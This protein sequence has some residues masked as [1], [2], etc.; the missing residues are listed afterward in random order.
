MA[1]L[2]TVLRQSPLTPKQRA[3]LWDLYQNAPDQDALTTALGGVNIPKE[4][5]AKLWDLK[6]TAL[7]VPAASE[8]PAGA[9]ALRQ[10]EGISQAPW[11]AKGMIAGHGPSVLQALEALPAVGGAVGGILGGGAGIPSGPGAVATAAGGA[12]LGGAAGE[13][14]RQLARRVIGASV[15]ATSGE[16]AL[17]IGKEAAIQGGAQAVGG[18]LAGGMKSGAARLMQ[19]AV[20][21]PLKMAKDVPKIVQTL[22]DE[23][24]NVS[25]RGVENLDRLLSA[26]NAEIA[27]AVANAPGLIPKERVA[28]R[29]LPVAQRLAR[30]VNPSADLEAVGS[31]VQ[32]FL[33]HPTTG[34][35]LTVPEAQAMKV[36]T[37]AQIG[38]N[39]GKLSSATVETQKALARGLKDE[40][41]AE[42]PQVAGLNA[43]ESRLILAR[44]AVGRRVALSG[45][46][47]PVGFAWVTS[48]PTTFLA[49]LID[50][51]PAVKSMLARGMYSSAGG[52]AKVSPQLIRAAVVALASREGETENPGQEQTQGAGAGGAND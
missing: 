51:A 28:A 13:S 29:A 41:V 17:D 48:H 42:A 49:A 38:K 43:A 36:G 7:A 1:D 22:L 34:A 31:T 33:Q 44:E 15:P 16:A 45:N 3:D 50:R 27:E 12:A 37:Y 14:A 32:E 8:A 40:I 6:G 5:K 9:A 26:K 20:K 35:A 4:V 39:Y 23:G 19:S 47:D 24:I 10:V 25:P 30:Q 52:A 18:T 11:Y 46:R 2:E 21:P